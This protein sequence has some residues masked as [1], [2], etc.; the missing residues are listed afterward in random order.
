MAQT[1]IELPVNRIKFYPN[2]VGTIG[3]ANRDDSFL[4]E[5]LD[6]YHSDTERKRLHDELHENAQASWENPETKRVTKKHFI[7]AI[8]HTLKKDP[9][10]G[11]HDIVPG[12]DV[13]EEE[14]T[15]SM[16][17]DDSELKDCFK[18][19]FIQDRVARDLTSDIIDNAWS[20]TKWSASAARDEFIGSLTKDFDR[21]GTWAKFVKTTMETC[22]KE[23]NLEKSPFFRNHND[24]ADFLDCLV[25][26]INGQKDDIMEGYWE[27]CRDN[28]YSNFSLNDEAF[29]RKL[30]ADRGLPFEVLEHCASF[31]YD[32]L[33]KYRPISEHQT[34]LE[35]YGAKIYDPSEEAEE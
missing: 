25:H 6:I 14:A 20:N 22:D 16:E 7:K 4:S 9:S 19:N 11:L 12:V 2:G 18:R 31:Q 8:E 30:A 15:S 33:E 3:Y 35:S 21:D 28:F 24:A 26:E 10:D 32:T 5:I 27:S 1:E 23:H 13:C 29:L 34:F 17:N